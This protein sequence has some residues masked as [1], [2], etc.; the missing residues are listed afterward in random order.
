MKPCSLPQPALGKAITQRMLT[1]AAPHPE[2][3]TN[4]PDFGEHRHV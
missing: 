2:R 1:L 4:Q 3:V